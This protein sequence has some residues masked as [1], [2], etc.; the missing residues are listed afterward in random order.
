MEDL[1]YFPFEFF[2]KSIESCPFMK[3]NRDYKEEPQAHN[4]EA[5]GSTH[6]RSETFV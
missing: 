1:S 2:K 6:E 4:P 3:L 5:A